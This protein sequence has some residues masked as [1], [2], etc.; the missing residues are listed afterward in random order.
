MNKNKKLLLIILITIIVGIIGF[1]QVMPIVL[2]KPNKD[3]SPININQA[4]N[5]QDNNMTLSFLYN[6]TKE[7]HP[8]CCTL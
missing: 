4:N 6:I 8:I 5:S 7:K 2:E 1:I 3:F